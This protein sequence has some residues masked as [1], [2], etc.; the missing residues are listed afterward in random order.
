MSDKEYNSWNVHSRVNYAV[1]KEKEGLSAEDAK[2]ES[3]K[4]FARHLPNGKNTPDHHIYAVTS[5][6]EDE[7]VGHLWWGLQN[8]GSKKIPW[9]FDIELNP[10]FRGRGFGRITMELAQADVKSKGYDRLG[11]HVFGHNKVARSL[12]ESLGF[13]TTNVVMSKELKD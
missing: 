2:A 4:S 13:E 9:I 10:K 8:H 1:E 7:V 12:Y 6:P 11:L 5:M 3:E